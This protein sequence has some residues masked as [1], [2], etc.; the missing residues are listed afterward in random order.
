[1]LTRTVTW[2]SR[3]P[4]KGPT[5]VTYHEIITKFLDQMGHVSISLDK[6]QLDKMGL[7]E[8]QRHNQYM[9]VDCLPHIKSVISLGKQHMNVTDIH[10]L[11]VWYDHVINEF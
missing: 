8:M 11:P 7:D 2:K 5:T 3:V 4:I 10:S 9:G 1:M 6:I